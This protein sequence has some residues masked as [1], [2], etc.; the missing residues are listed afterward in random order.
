MADTEIESNAQA[1]LLATFYVGDALCALDAAGVQEVI[2]VESVTQVRHAPPE[3]VGVMN[4]R[5]KIVTLLDPRIILG[6][7]QSVLTRESRVFVIEDR[8][9][10]LGVLVDRAG[11]V[12]E[13]EPGLQESLPINIPAAQARFF[14]QV[15][16]VGGQVVAVLNPRE[17][18]NESSRQQSSPVTASGK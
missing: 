15:C 8:N 2:R 16:R 4:L 5:G 14:Q 18:L 6:L 7:G 12:M 10:F 1:T 17:I 3:V 9:E 13:V 11:E